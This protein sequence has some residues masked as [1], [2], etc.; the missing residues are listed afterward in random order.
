M[1][2]AVVDGD[3]SLHGGRQAADVAGLEAQAATVVHEHAE[4]VLC[5]PTPLR[6]DGGGGVHRNY[7]R[8][9]DP[10]FHRDSRTQARGIQS[11]LNSI[12]HPVKAEKAG[13]GFRNSRD[14]SRPAERHERIGIEVIRNA[15][16]V[17]V[18]LEWIGAE[19]DLFRVG[20]IVAIGI[21]AGVV[22]EGI[23]PV[24][25]L[26]PVVDPVVVAVFGAR[27]DV[28][29]DGAQRHR[30]QI[31]ATHCIICVPAEEERGRSELTQERNDSLFFERRDIIKQRPRSRD[32][33]QRASGRSRHIDRLDQRIGRSLHQEL[34]RLSFHHLSTVRRLHDSETAGRKRDARR[35][36]FIPRQV[37]QA[38]SEF[39]GVSLLEFQR[40]GRGEFYAAISGGAA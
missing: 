11:C 37:R 38:R 10:A 40:I 24:V 19:R 25:D 2:L 8:G 18:F 36:C 16:T 29:G 30:R 15:V 7:L 34:K 22:G 23:E 28:E 33:H 27:V 6:H 26:G 5:A 31:H 17:G 35:C 1:P 39:R 14:G 3:A 9:A 21:V 32:R 12:V 4:G 20:E 13:G